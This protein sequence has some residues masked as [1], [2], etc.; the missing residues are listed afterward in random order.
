MRT[1]WIRVTKWLHMVTQNNRNKLKQPEVTNK[2]K[3][4]LSFY[5]YI[6]YIYISL[7]IYIHPYTH[8]L[9]DITYEI[10]RVKTLLYL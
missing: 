1:N 7:Y 8:T 5:I 2:A 9:K 6:I 4:S 3:I 10:I